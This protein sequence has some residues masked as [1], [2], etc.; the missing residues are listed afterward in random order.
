MKR[1]GWREIWYEWSDSNRQSDSSEADFESAASTNSATPASRPALRRA[2]DRLCTPYKWVGAR[3]PAGLWS[4][5]EEHTSEIQS[6]MRSSYAVFC[7][8]QTTKRNQHRT[9]NLIPHRMA[10]AHD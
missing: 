2:K 6:L 8:K 5:S 9:Q 4:R 1:A 3:L 10:R 7:L